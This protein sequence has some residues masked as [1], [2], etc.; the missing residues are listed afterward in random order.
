MTRNEIINKLVDVRRDNPNKFYDT[1]KAIAQIEG[2]P[3]HDIITI[4]NDF[5]DEEYAE[6]GED[7][8][9]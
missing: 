7:F 9:E 2:R 3:E 6:G 1:V 4:Y 5:C 8:D